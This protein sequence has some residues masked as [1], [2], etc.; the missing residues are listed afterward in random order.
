[1]LEQFAYSLNVVAPV[2][3]LLAIGS[4]IRHLNIVTESGFRQL[5]RLCFMLLLPSNVFYSIASAKQD[6]FNLQFG[7]LIIFSLITIFL[8]GMIFVPRFVSDPAKRGVVIQSLIRGNFVIF[9]FAIL[10]RLYNR[11]NFADA[12]L[13]VLI[14][15][16]FYNPTSVIA[17]ERYQTEKTPL[18]G[19]IKKVLSNP[20]VIATFLGLIGML[21]SVPNVVMAPVKL[22]A[23]AS[24]TI[25]L[26]SLGGLLELTD[27]RTNKYTLMAVSFIRLIIVPVIVLFIAYHLGFDEQT[28]MIVMLLFGSPVAVV[29]FFMVEQLGGDEVLAGQLILFTTIMSLFSYTVW[30]AVIRSLFV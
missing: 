4:V 28:M 25:A 16:I 17:L 3:I 20:M 8:A 13:A 19:T 7:L 14:T 21:L 11:S 18:L 15:M 1:M 5:N 10:E 27:L 9:G 12:G 26:I 29:S 23:S 2:F 6:E 24:G 22:M 30:I